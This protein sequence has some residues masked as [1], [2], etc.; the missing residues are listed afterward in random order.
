M[1]KI[2]KIYHFHYIFTFEFTYKQLSNLCSFF[3]FVFGAL[4]SVLLT[5]CVGNDS[6]YWEQNLIYTSVQRELTQILLFSFKK[7]R[8]KEKTFKNHQID[9]YQ[10][11]TTLST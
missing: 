11:R 5:R 8:S 10:Q 9:L 4:F 7:K 1:L 6:G 2:F 3:C